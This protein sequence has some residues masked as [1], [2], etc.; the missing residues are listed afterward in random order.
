M[1]QF[2]CDVVQNTGKEVYCAR[3]FALGWIRE[4]DHQ[5]IWGV[6]ATAQLLEETLWTASYHLVEGDWYWCT[7]SQSTSGST[8]PGERPVTARSGDVSST[9]QHF[10]I[11]HAPSHW[12][13]NWVV[14]ST[15]SL[16]VCLSVCLHACLKIASLA[17]REISRAC[18]MRIWPWLEPHL[19]TVQRAKHFRF[20]WM[21]S[22]FS[23]KVEVDAN[24]ILFYFISV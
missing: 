2:G 4:D 19:T 5:F 12:R 1:L 3:L 10:V 21:T 17:P 24:F 6:A 18:Y 20:L 22:C 13:R 11:G 23:I 14:W 7:Y 16:Y 15:A 8:R 9:W